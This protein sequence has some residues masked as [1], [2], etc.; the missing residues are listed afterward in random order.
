MSRKGNSWDNAVAQSFFSSL[1]KERFK[2]HVC[3]NRLLAI[4]GLSD[5]IEGFHNRKR[6]HSHLG[7]VSPEASNSAHRRSRRR[8]H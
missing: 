5:Y 2:R 1:K 4:D 3:E 7:G 6:R 8:V